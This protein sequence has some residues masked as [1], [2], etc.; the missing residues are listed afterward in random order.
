MYTIAPPERKSTLEH[1]TDPQVRSYA[2]LVRVLE[3]APLHNK[4]PVFGLIARTAAADTVAI[5]QQYVDDVWWLAEQTGLVTLLGTVPV[6]D[7]LAS[8]FGG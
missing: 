5:R 3:A 4:L 6:Q 2:S 1:E 7:V 8:A